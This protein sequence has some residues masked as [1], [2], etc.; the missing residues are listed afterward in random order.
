MSNAPSSQQATNTTLLKQATNGYS[1]FSHIRGSLDIAFGHA[2]T[3]TANSARI[4]G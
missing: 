4:P 2:N 1:I 3:S